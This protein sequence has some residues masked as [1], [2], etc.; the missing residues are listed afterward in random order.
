MNILI[1]LKRTKSEDEFNQKHELLLK[2]AEN[3]AGKDND[4]YVMSNATKRASKHPTVSFV[5]PPSYLFNNLLVSAWFSMVNHPRFDFIIE[6]ASFTPFIYRKSE[7][8]FYLPA[9]LNP[10]NILKLAVVKRLFSVMMKLY[11]RKSYFLT[12]SWRTSDFLLTVGVKPDKVYLFKKGLNFGS[13][14]R[15]KIRTGKSLLTILGNNKEKLSETFQVLKAIERRDLDW[16]FT[17][18]VPDALHAGSKEMLIN[19]GITSPTQMIARKTPKQVLKEIE[20]CNLL[21]DLMANEDSLNNDIVALG[22]QV[23]V[24]SIESDFFMKNK[25]IAK[26]LFL[27]PEKDYYSLAQDVLDFSKDV[28]K[29]QKRVDISEELV[30]SHT[31]KNLS[32]QS[33]NFLGNIRL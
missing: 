16:R 27:N 17:I 21:L 30:K 2:H 24:V 23:P 31:W 1:V 22:L 10:E 9:F 18:I 14:K 28:K 4:V 8:I 33:L 3:W 6:E 5:N 15:T 29:Y 7:K 19:S 26:S 20:K 32:E 25:D 13:K 12:T 11:Y